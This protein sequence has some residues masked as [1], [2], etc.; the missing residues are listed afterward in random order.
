MLPWQDYGL[1]GLVV[2]VLLAAFVYWIKAA[3]ADLRDSQRQFVDHL[4]D[5][6]AR[7]TE[8]IVASAVATQQSTKTLEKVV[9]AMNRHDSKAEIR[10]HDVMEKLEEIH[11][12]Q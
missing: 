11:G 2:G 12:R 10:H 9:E 5:T 7:Q 8:A 6:G 1:A 3:R 4:K